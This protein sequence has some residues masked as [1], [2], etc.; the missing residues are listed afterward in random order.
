MK[1]LF[2]KF[3]TAK[4]K[5]SGNLVNLWFVFFAVAITLYFLWNKPMLH[6]LKNLQPLGFSFV[7][8]LAFLGIGALPARWFH[9]PSRLSRPSKTD[10]I[11]TAFA[12][13]LGLTALFVFFLGIL[14]IVNTMIYA[15]WVL[16]GL[17]L[18][19]YTLLTHWMPVSVDFDAKNP[20]NLLGMLILLPLLLQAIPPLVT[21]PVST[22]ALE[23]HLL[24]PK[25]FLMVGKIGYIPSLVES[26][27]PCMAEFVYMP[28]MAIGGDI[29]CKCLHFWTGVFLL[30]TMARLSSKIY[31]EGSRLLGPALYVSM[32]V[33]MV[34]F[35]W[36]WNDLFFVFFLLLCLSYFLDHHDNVLGNNVEN[37]KTVPLPPARILILAGITAG[38]A[39][40]MKYTIVMMVFVFLLLLLVARFKWQWRWR[41]LFYFFIPMGA[42]FMLVLTKN[43]VFTGNPF[44]PFLNGIF[45]SPY[46]NETAA[47]YFMNAVQRWE[48]PDWNWTTYFTFPF[49]ITLKPLLIDTHPG[50]L[51]IV[52][53]PLLFFRSASRGMTLLKAFVACHVLV[54]LVF[55]TETRS[56]LTLLAVLFVTAAVGLEQK[57]WSNKN[58]RR[59]LVF[60]LALAVAVS[61]VPTIT[62]NYYLTRPIKHLLGLE[63][64]GD[65]LNR[66]AKGQ[67]AYAWLNANPNVGK[68]L[69]VGLYNP[70]YLERPVF[71]SSVCDPP[72]V[73]VLVSGATSPEELHRKLSALGITHVV[74]RKL[75]YER[76]LSNGLFSWGADE[77]RVFEQ[78]IVNTCKPAAQ[79]GKE[80]IYR[81]PAK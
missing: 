71:F 12:L 20:L 80:L 66:E 46:W 38:L 65:F 79:F 54:W 37:S 45:K 10:E 34:I 59:P 15:L 51:P 75:Q 47:A 60:L 26:N 62:T 8:V 33:V 35:G 44:Y 5:P 24:I 22:D 50:I 61:L 70:Y 81:I 68:V 56:M 77:R 40:W 1:E 18:F 67:K 16:A 14:G 4:G 42:L 63:N 19:V 41:D 69:L 58:F 7:F 78:F 73:E 36:A 52:L 13:G 3:G 64:K 17:G 43:W 28:V 6:A 48:I 23:Y 29:A 39:A 27:Y 55:Q 30:I 76:D 25:I 57:I 9:G 11:L 49:H 32:P 74:I 2:N 53:A 21:P 31:P 72:I